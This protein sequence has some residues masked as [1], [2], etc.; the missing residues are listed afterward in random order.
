MAMYF[1][2]PGN[3]RELYSNC[4]SKIKSIYIFISCHLDI[5]TGLGSIKKGVPLT[6]SCLELLS[7]GVE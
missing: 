2:A 1:C 6:K 3:A 5:C 4:K 7:Q